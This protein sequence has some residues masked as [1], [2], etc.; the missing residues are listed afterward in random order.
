M[1]S[2][3]SRRRIERLLNEADE[4]VHQLGWETVSA[5]ATA[6]LTLQ[7]DMLMPKLCGPLPLGRAKEGLRREERYLCGY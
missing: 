5:H 1:A 2:E 3:R 6:V 7:A 4:A